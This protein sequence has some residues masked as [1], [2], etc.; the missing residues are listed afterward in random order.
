MDIASFTKTYLV[1]VPIFFLMDMVW[2]GVVAKGIYGKY[3]GH[4][5]RPVPNWPAAV[6]FYL[7]FIV[8]LI[9]FVIQPALKNHSL[10]Y[11]LLYGGM[12]GFFTYMTFDMT[13]LAVLKDYPW[14]IVIVDTIWGVVL[15][16]SVC[17]LTYL[18]SSKYLGL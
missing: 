6:A 5:M 10:P 11:A 1:A 18:V 2:L 8:G 4:L 17:S 7:M 14:Q 15:A 13:A 9:I 3:L 12:F 16:G